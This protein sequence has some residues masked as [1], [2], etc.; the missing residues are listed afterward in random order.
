MATLATSGSGVQ[1]KMGDGGVGAGVQA[2][3]TISTSNQQIIIYA[4][5]AGTAG[6]SKTCSIVVSGNNTAF[7]LSV[8]SS[9][10]TITSATDGSG[11]ATTTVNEALYQLMQNDTF[12]LHWEATRGAGNGTGIL[13][14]AAS[15]ALSG[16]TN[17]TE[18]FTA[19]AEVKSITGPNMSASVIDVTNMDS[20]NNTREFISS[21]IDPGELSFAMNF[22]P[23]NTTQQNLATLMQSRTRRN[24]QLV[25]SDAA[26]TVCAMSGLVTA[27]QITNQLDAAL[28]ANVTIKLTGF[29]TW[30]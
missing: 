2:S 9:N 10:I 7:A 12:A 8:T 27:F 4:K 26:A 14:A 13:V 5:T 25:W 18:I 29:P 16:G 23:A 1:F 11:V 28:E 19:V 22:L 30:F 15:A 3:R 20:A 21:W 24:M 17:G 6:N